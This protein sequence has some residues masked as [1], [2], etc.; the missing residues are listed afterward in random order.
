MPEYVYKAVTKNGL[1][2]RN[3]VEATSK[4]NLISKLKGNELLPVDIVQV[5]FRYK[6][7]EKSKEKK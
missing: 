7:K 6:K 4:Q 5:R 2:V 1:I 3:R